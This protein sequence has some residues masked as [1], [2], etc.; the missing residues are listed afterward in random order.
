MEIISYTV[1]QIEDPTGIL[2]GE[3]YE[4]F[5]DIQVEED[6]ELF[7]ENGISLRVLY[8]KDDQASRILNYHFISGEQILNF[9]L[10]EDEEK[11]VEAF[12]NEHYFEL[13]N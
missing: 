6:D 5:L 12:C 7:S 8:Y 2:T 10:D 4:F 11:I 1:E 9:A 3:R 13:E